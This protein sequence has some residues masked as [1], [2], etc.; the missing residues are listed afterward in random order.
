[1][2]SSVEF[3]EHGGA[4]EIVSRSQAKVSDNSGSA[5]LPPRSKNARHFSQGVR[6]FSQGVI[7]PA[8]SAVN[9]IRK[10]LVESAFCQ[11]CDPVFQHGAVGEKAGIFSRAVRSMA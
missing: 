8:A 3:A 6:N 4:E 7:T 1:M 10:D 11:F 2:A 9:S 5:I